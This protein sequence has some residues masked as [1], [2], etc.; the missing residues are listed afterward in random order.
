[1]RT[2]RAVVIIAVMSLLL[3]GAAF[4]TPARADGAEIALIATAA[5]AGY[6]A[7]VVIGTILVNR[8][9]SSWAEIPANLQVDGKRPPAAVRFGPKCR[10]G[11]AQLTL[12]CW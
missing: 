9:R 12:V 3:I 1:M 5:T 10:Q 2:K 11:S 4:P 7:L 6:V 8:S